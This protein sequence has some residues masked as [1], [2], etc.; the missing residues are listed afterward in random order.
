MQILIPHQ[1]NGENG[2]FNFARNTLHDMLKFLNLRLTY[3]DLIKLIISVS[4]TLPRHDEKT[5]CLGTLAEHCQHIGFRHLGSKLFTKYF[6]GTIANVVFCRDPTK[7]SDMVSSMLIFKCNHLRF[8]QLP[9]CVTDKF[10][11]FDTQLRVVSDRT[12]RN[13]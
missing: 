9:G 7:V 8:C 5:P 4:R 10:F 11:S 12:S 6:H 3:L 2:H 1:E 13:A